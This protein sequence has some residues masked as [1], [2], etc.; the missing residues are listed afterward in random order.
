M[1]SIL[2]KKKYPEQYKTIKDL[3]DKLEVNCPI[4]IVKED[5]Y[6]GSAGGSG[7]SFPI[8]TIEDYMI[9]P[10]VLRFF[11]AHELIHYK[12][13][14]FGV[15]RAVKLTTAMFLDVIGV[16]GP[17]RY[18]GAHILLSEMRANIE[19]AALANLTSE[20][21]VLSQD[22]TQRKNNDPTRPKSYLFGYPDREMIKEYALRYTKLDEF[23]ASE[24]LE[25]Y[26][27]AL[28]IRNKHYFSKIIIKS[29]FK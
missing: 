19:G 16:K 10:Y 23:V 12:H 22:E 15:W 6:S 17:F 8:A 24:I 18:L 11:A 1:K 21:L 13:R 5:R 29:F 27:K 20:E 14:E 26:C 3:M 7:I 9:H 25:D 2:L 4:Y 28:K